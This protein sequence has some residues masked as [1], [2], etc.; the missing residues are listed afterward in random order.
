MR[1]N[2]ADLKE[3][4]REAWL[5]LVLFE[6]CMGG[7]AAAHV[8]SDAAIAKEIGLRGAPSFIVGLQVDGERVRASGAIAGADRK[9]IDEALE[10]AL[11]AVP[12][13]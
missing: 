12:N 3:Y 7:G 2:E 13:R 1:L 9:A 8:A 10:A 11:K 4:R 5:D 6:T